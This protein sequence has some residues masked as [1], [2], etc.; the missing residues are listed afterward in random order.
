METFLYGT[1]FNIYQIMY[2]VVILATCSQRAV[3]M[4]DDG[5]L[6]CFIH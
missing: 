5:V 1:S 6:P 4:V 3:V 2:L